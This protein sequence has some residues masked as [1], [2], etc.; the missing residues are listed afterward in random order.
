M[1][2]CGHIL[3]WFLVILLFL[4]KLHFLHQEFGC[5]FVVAL[6]WTTVEVKRANANRVVDAIK[7]EREGMEPDS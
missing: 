6:G 2:F 7:E 5:D 1:V 4:D 3:R